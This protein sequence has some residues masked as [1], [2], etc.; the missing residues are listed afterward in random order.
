MAPRRGL[1]LLRWVEGQARALVSYGSAAGELTARACSFSDFF[2]LP[3]ESPIP[4]V[5]LCLPE[6]T[7]QP[8]G[9]RHGHQD[10]RRVQL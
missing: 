10:S 5:R 2:R 3:L 4:V 1:E 6:R 7:G 9:V 8:E